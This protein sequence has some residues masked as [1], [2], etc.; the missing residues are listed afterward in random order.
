MPA[1][2]ISGFLSSNVNSHYRVVATI[3]KEIIAI[4]CTISAQIRGIVRVN[5]SANGGIIVTA[6]E[7]VEACFGVEVIA[8][9]ADGVGGC[10]GA[11][12]GE[13]VAP[14]VVG[15]GGEDCS[16]GRDDSLDVALLVLY[17]DA[18]RFGVSGFIGIAYQFAAGAVVEVECI[19]RA[20][21]RHELAAVP[22]IAARAAVY[23]LFG[24]QSGIVVREGERR[25]VLLHGGK[26]PPA[27]PRHAPAAVIRRVAD[28][29]VGYGFA[30]VG[31]E[32]IAPCSIPISVR[33]RDGI[34]RL[35]VRIVVFGFR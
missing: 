14:G 5:E 27:L 34:G 24:A 9:V 7:I 3:H 19:A 17:E 23:R 20:N 28:S 2:P 8:P 18:L 12:G 30:V 26:L 11:F 1:L 29:V 33:D 31:G 32:Q 16:V 35:P 13:R 6:L 4:I 22:D 25:A 15:I 21:V 10:D